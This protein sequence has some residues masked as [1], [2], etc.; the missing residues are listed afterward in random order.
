MVTVLNRLFGRYLRRHREQTWCRGKVTK[1]TEMEQLR[2]HRWIEAGRLDDEGTDP[3][4]AGQIS[5]EDGGIEAA[6]ASFPASA[7]R[8]EESTC[9]HFEDGKNTLLRS[10]SAMILA[11]SEEISLYALVGSAIIALKQGERL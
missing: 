9:N 11:V 8:G 2:N 5:D 6:T 3:D 10:I 7:V 4:V 1:G